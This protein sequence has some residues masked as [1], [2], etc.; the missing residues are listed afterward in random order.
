MYVSRLNLLPDE[1][2]K[3]IIEYS[4]SHIKDIPRWN[5][6]TKKWRRHC[7][8]KCYICNRSSYFVSLSHLC[9]CCL[10]NCSGVCNNQLICWECAH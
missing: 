7:N 3:I 10:D 2:Y 4:T 8:I 5:N 6:E 1:I 9:D